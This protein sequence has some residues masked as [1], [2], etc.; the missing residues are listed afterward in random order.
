MAAR[1]ISISMDDELEARVREAATREGLTFSAYI[2]RAAD[3]QAKLDA[4]RAFIAEY[5]A[6]HGAFTDEEMAE[7]YRTLGWVVPEHLARTA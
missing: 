3:H 2:A 5:E 1:K 6:E 4:S 7:A